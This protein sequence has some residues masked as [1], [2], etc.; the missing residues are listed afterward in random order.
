MASV[1]EY[2]HC[3]E[4][5]T[6]PSQCR[7]NY[8]REHELLVNLL[9]QKATVLQVG[10][11]D[12][13]RAV[14][15]LTARPDLD[16]TGLDIEDELVE[17]ARDNVAAAKLAAKFFVGD[18]VHPP[19][20]KRFDYVLCLNNTLGYISNQR[21]AIASMK[22]LG[23]KVVISVYGERFTDILAQAYFS[24]IGSDI[25]RI[26]GNTFMMKGDWLVRRFSHA[27]VV[28]WGGKVTE[29]PIGYWCELVG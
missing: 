27:E 11:M 8:L 28:A 16:F 1:E 21:Q 2:V 3:D 26:E 18:I 12:G 19:S 24:S 15:L 29:T 6:I 4:L 5:D 20:F 17:K 14:R 7:D 9:P 23:K 22:D 10:S 13:M 25:D